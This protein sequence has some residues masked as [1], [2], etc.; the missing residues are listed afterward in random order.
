MGSFYCYISSDDSKAL[1]TDN[2][3][4]DFIVQFPSYIKL[5]ESCSLG[6]KQYWHIGITEISLIL[7]TQRSITSLPTSCVILCNLLSESY[8]RGSYAPVLRIL[9]GGTE[10]SA[11]LGSVYYKQVHSNAQSFNELRIQIKDPDLKPLA[12]EKWPRNAKISMTLHFMKG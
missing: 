4:F 5:E 12:F 7:D 3:Y 9:P 2:S 10:L 8:L 1:Y 11:S 6:W